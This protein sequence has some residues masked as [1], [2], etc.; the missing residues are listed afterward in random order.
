MSDI[1]C[2]TSR[3]LCEGD[4]IERLEKI[5]AAA[6]ARIILRE[7]ELPE[8]EYRVLA[9]K[10]ME[11]CRKFDTELTLHF[12]WK[13]AIELGAESVHLPLHVLRQLSSADKS[14]FRLIGVSCHSAEEAAEAERLGAGYI[15]AGHIFAT[16]CKKGLEPRGL[17]FLRSVCDSV[18]LPVYAIGGI[19]PENI[20]DVRDCGALGACV[21]SGFMKCGDPKAF[22]RKFDREKSENDR[23]E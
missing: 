3:E 15:T 7:K 8:S 9:Q 12:F 18:S 20:A 14:H 21:M 10:A 17:R 13:T 19:T 16:D 6:P 11:I 5:A 23:Q 4:F 1:I 22:I 2:V